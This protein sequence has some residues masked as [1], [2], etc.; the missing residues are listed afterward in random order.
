MEINTTNPEKIYYY[1]ADGTEPP[2]DMELMQGQYWQS[3]HW[4]KEYIMFLKFKPSRVWWGE[5]VKLNQFA[6]DNDSVWSKKPTD[7]PVWF[8]PSENSVRYKSNNPFDQGS[9]YFCDT[10]TE[11]CYIYEIQL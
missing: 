11:I 3:P 8:S 5:F 9:R 7:V 1:W 6:V 10:I 4:T 2:S